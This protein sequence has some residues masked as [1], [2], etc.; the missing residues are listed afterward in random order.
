MNPYNPGAGTEP[1]N[2]IG[3]EELLRSF[4][5]SLARTMRGAPGKSLM[6]IGLRGV[7]KTVLLNKFVF[8]AQE[9]GC[10]VAFIEA[11]ETATFRLILASQLRKVLADLDRGG[12]VSAVIRNAMGILRSFSLTIGLDGAASV[13]FS[14]AAIEGVADSGL[15]SEDVTDL[16]EA[17]GSA[18][19]ERSTAVVIAIDEVQYL[20]EEEFAGV[21]SGIHRTTQLGLP[22]MLVG[23]GLPAL[24]MLAGNAK[25]YAERLF[26]FP[27]IRSLDVADARRAIAEPANAMDVVFSDEALTSMVEVTEGYPY[28][29]QEWSYEVWNAAERSP[30]EVTVVNAVHPIVQAKLDK[31]FF[32]VRLDRL[33]PTERRYLRAMSELG[34]GPHRSGDIAAAY[35]AS[36]ISVAPIRSN[37]IR[38]G[39]VYSPAHGDT[40]FTVPLF[41]GFMRRTLPFEPAKVR[42]NTAN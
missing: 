27:R 41:D 26:D 15:F 37:L 10:K 42:R 3:R 25:S 20:S 18:A 23:T 30:I 28:F 36:V 35:G 8:N 39:M 33:T 1:P 17:V 24:P 4:D 7:G 31:S 19:R 13:A 6:P 34:P 32:S 29:I 12:P 14:G 16:F 5:I 38:K 22:V 11:P 9:R 21:I 40:A 2:F